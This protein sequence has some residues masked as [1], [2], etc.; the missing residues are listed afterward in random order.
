MNEQEFAKRL[1]RLHL[2]T[3]H[4]LYQIRTEK[5]YSTEEAATMAGISV[6]RLEM[7]EEGDTT[8]IEEIAR[9]CA[10]YGVSF[11]ITPDLQPMVSPAKALPVV[12]LEA[13]YAQ[14]LG[15]ASSEL[16]RSERDSIS[17]MALRSNERNLTPG[18]ANAG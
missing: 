1:A 17:A 12:R 8:D 15:C 11:E 2:D 16:E 13:R 6:Q 14:S 9:L 3:S 18:F 5:G 7:V 4:K 10:A